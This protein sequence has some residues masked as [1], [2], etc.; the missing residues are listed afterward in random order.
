MARDKWQ[1]ID[2]KP[3]FGE[4][5]KPGYVGFTFTDGSFLS[6]GIAWFTRWD[7]KKGGAPNLKLSHTIIVIDK[8]TCIEATWPK[9]KISP[10]SNYFNDDPKHICF[11]KPKGLTPEIAKE[12][13]EQGKIRIG[14]HY[15]ISV[16]V[17]QFLKKNI[18]GR[19]FSFLTFRLS[20]KVLIKVFDAARAAVCSEFVAWCMKAAG[21]EL[22]RIPADY[23]LQDLFH[24]EDL[25]EPW[26]TNEM[27]S[28]DRRS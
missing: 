8:D 22:K 26:D 9:I 27:P 17:G 11:R 21:Y 23:T 4:N 5:Y 12:M 3:V 6:S 2:T 10:L 20:D 18:F 24:D 28:E 13:I 16:I 14:E 25:F 15:D 7:A 19:V 1:L